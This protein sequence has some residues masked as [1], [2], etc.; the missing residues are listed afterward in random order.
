MS[1]TLEDKVLALAGVVQAAALV[2]DVATGQRMDEASLHATLGSI[3]KTEAANVVEVFGGL[4]GLR[5]GL[6]RLAGLLGNEHNA[7]DVV[8]LRYTLSLLQLQ[9][10]VMRRRTLKQVIETGIKRA[11][12][13]FRH[14]GPTHANVLANLADTYLHSAGTIQP[15]IMVTG[16]SVHLQ[17]QRVINMVRSLLLGGLRAAVLWHQCS[18]SRWMLLFMRASLHK[19]AKRLLREAHHY[20]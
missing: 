11:H 3:L 14:F 6:Q 19:E 10:K 15:R 2:N 7:S 17:N 5:Y 20:A 18:G 13:Q 12:D 8:I 16:D 9:G 1:R 4:P